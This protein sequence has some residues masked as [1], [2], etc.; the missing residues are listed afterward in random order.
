VDGLPY[1]LT[2]VARGEDRYRDVSVFAPFA[3]VGEAASAGGMLARFHLA[4]Q[5]FPMP[6]PK[7][8]LGIT[9]RFDWLRAPSS[10][11]GLGDL[12]D[13]A[14]ILAPFL[15]AQPEFPE[16]VVY[17]EERHVRLAPIVSALPSGV[18]H[19]DFIKRN[20]F[21]EADAVSDVLDFD[22]W[23]VGPWVYDLALALLPC[24]FDWEAIARGAEPRGADMRAFLE[25]YQAVRPLTPPEAEA[26]KTVMETARVEIYLSL[27]AMALRQHD[28]DM[29]KLFWGFVVTLVRWFGV[30]VNWSTRLR[31]RGAA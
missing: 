3:S 30:N 31:E 19:G 1:A 2:A 5:D 10:A 17:M 26:L 11:Q 8:F 16:L 7:P 6:T 4:L 12:L 14:P 23:N 29:A 24:G 21:Y 18:I 27:V 20:L 9:A 22:L 25:G 13:E 28:D 15:E